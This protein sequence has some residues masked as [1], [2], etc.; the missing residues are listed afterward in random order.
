MI[1]NTR[2]ETRYY[3]KNDRP[4]EILNS[5]QALE[6]VAITRMVFVTVAILGASFYN[7]GKT[8]S[9]K[10]MLLAS[11]CGSVVGI[12]FGKA[13]THIFNKKPITWKETLEIVAVQVPA[14]LLVS[15]FV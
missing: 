1:S 2:L 10:N 11:A 9:S 14:I 3:R 5:H 7:N 6:T 13:M 15:L 8:V 4:S 12:V